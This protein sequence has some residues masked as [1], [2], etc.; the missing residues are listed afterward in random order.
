MRHC[1][2][3]VIIVLMCLALPFQGVAGALRASCGSSLQAIMVG[4]ATPGSVGAVSDQSLI[5]APMGHAG[6]AGHHDHPA[7]HPAAAAAADDDGA[8]PSHGTCSACAACCAGT[9][10]PSAWPRLPQPAV[11]V[12]VFADEPVRVV[13]MPSDGPDRPPRG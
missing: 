13:A 2:R 11:E 12:T 8:A 6:H 7:Q 5:L 9:A 4:G 10:P 3:L 1:V